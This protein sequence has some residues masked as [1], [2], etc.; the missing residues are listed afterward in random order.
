MDANAGAAHV[1]ARELATARPSQ[2]IR[3]CG[4][5]HRRARLAAVGALVDPRSS[6]SGSP[7]RWSRTTRS[8]SSCRS[9]RCSLSCS[10]PG[11]SWPGAACCDCSSSRSASW[12]SSP[13]SHTAYDQKYQL[14]V[15]IRD[16]ARVRLRRPV[17]DAHTSTRSAHATHRHARAAEPARNGV[18]IINPKLRWREGRALQPARGGE[19]D[20][21]IEPVV[22]EPGDD[23]C[24]LADGP[25][26][27]VQTSSAWQAATA[28]RRWSRRWRWS[29]T[30]PT[31]ACLSGT[32]NHFALDLGL[33]RDD[34]VGALDAFTDGVERRID[35]ASPQRARLRQQRFARRLCARRPVG[36][37]PRRQAR[38][39]ETDAAGDG[40]SGRGG[41][42]PPVRGAARARLVRRRARDRLEQPVSDATFSRRWARGRCSTRVGSGSSPPGSAVPGGVAKLVTLGIDRSAPAL[43]RRAP[44]VEPR[45]RGAVAGAR[46]GR[47]RRRG[48][49]LDA[50]AAFRLVARRSAGPRAAARPRRVARGR[51]GPADPP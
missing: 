33:D 4:R 36:C 1:F 44:V 9:C 22:L 10:P 40:R 28:P 31:C 24:E 32:R 3:P 43:W 12:R 7:S 2:A 8:V 15:L 37:V 41:L 45:V 14:L 38:D 13:W 35:L 34:V 16:A 25:S 49:R 27:V 30:L 6:S 47:A 5:A 46:I 50:P 42:Q 20:A 51:S 17:R 29:T 26:H 48:A 11:F 39:L 21:A 18:L 23:L 19:E